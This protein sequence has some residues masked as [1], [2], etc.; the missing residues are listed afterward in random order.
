M[1]QYSDSEAAHF[2]DVEGAVPRQASTAGHQRS[3][4]RVRHIVAAVA[5][6]AAVAT[7]G[8]SAYYQHSPPQSQKLTARMLFESPA[9]HDV[10]TDNVM[11]I[12]THVARSSKSRGEVHGLV[13]ETFRAIVG[14]MK[15]RTPEMWQALESTELTQE[16]H[17][18]IV[19]M[20][21]LLK[22][23]R[24]M[25]V[26]LDTAKALQ[27]ADSDDEETLKSHIVK[28]LKPH[29]W[30]IQEI[31]MK[32][33]PHQS[34]V[35][36]QPGDGFKSIL[37]PE[38]RRILKTVRGD[39]YQKFTGPS[40]VG[41]VERKLVWGP[42]TSPAFQQQ[43]QPVNPSSFLMTSYS[44]APATAQ[45]S[46]MQHVP[47]PYQ[48]AEEVMGI[49]STAIAEADCLIRMINPLEKIM[50][51]GHDLKIPPMVTSG[52][53]GADFAVQTADCE[54]D[55]VADHMNPMEMFGCPMMSASAG[56]DMLREP[57]T[58]L[59][60]LGDNKD[61]N[62]HQGNHAGH[63]AHQGIL[64]DTAEGKAMKREEKG[65]FPFCMF[66]G[67]HTCKT[68]QEA[69]QMAASSSASTSRPP[70]PAGPLPTT[71]QTKK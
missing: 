19:R 14:N 3:G 33:M 16:Q 7:C 20:M 70:P 2:L 9:V 39:G 67:M 71:T 17:D 60:L 42:Q 23:P 12:K 27:E 47:H 50:P 64:D 57:L 5:G 44:T 65:V 13:Q 6:A 28:K 34:F 30:D 59:G 36:S 10:A 40:D 22:D 69:T 8:A 53:G 68:G 55:A 62:G 1:A 43:A 66:W 48:V 25:K 37:S 38:R 15:E 32:S 24:V 58:L 11:N 54:M 52:L 26:G 35:T 46:W 18:D 45:H 4:F 61:A 21:R 51:G 63:H 29:A 49:V 31:Y 56:F 41:A